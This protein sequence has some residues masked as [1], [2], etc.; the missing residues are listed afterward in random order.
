MENN[1][2][3]FGY[4]DFTFEIEKNISSEYKNVYIFKLGQDGEDSFDL[5]DNWDNLSS[6]VDISDCVAFCVLEDMAENIFLTISLRDAFKDLIIVALAQD[7]ESADK[8]TLA[9]ATRVLPTT[10]TT[11]NVIVEMLEKP[12]VTEVLHDI[13]YEKSALQIAQIKIEDHT[14]FDGKYPADIEWSSKHGIIVISV[15]HEDMS[16]EFIYS[17]KA[18]H[19]IIKSGD[20]FVVVGYE[21]DIKE[22]EKLIGSKCE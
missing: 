7:K 21:H 20:I 18:K 11:A 17:S 8:L 9:G 16:R 4:N 14:V 6:K 10:Q 1:A 5:G 15:V 22:F 19:H 2:L 12:I 13:L 3:I